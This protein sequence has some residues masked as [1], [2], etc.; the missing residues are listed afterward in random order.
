MKL[1]DKLSKKQVMGSYYSDDE[2]KDMMKMSPA[3]VMQWL[4]KANGFINKI[5]PKPRKK[6]QERL[7]AEGW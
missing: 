3:R 1:K 6:I 4:E 7:I 2:L 5:S